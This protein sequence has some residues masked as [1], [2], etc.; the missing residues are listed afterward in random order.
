VSGKS[1]FRGTGV[2]ESSQ[3]VLG[4]VLMFCSA[5]SQSFEVIGE[6]MRSVGGGGGEG[7]ACEGDCGA[8]W[9]GS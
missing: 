1:L 9:E 2:S 4:T 6:N 5:S 7:Y 3:E 8:E